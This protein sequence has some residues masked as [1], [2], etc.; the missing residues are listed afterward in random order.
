MK[1]EIQL[2]KNEKRGIEPL[3]SKRVKGVKGHYVRMAKLC[4]YCKRKDFHTARS[5]KWKPPENVLNDP[6]QLS[7][8]H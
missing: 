7:Q 6:L 4:H 3:I 5:C 1:A 8:W 2:L